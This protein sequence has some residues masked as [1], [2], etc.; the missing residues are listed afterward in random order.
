MNTA[1]GLTF[2]GTFAIAGLATSI[3][4]GL[5]PVYQLLL[6]LMLLD[7]VTGLLAAGAAK[8]LSSDVSFR[9]MFKKGIIILLVVAAHM[10]G[11]Q[12]GVPAGVGV[13]GFYCAHELLSIIENAGRAGVPVP[14]ILKQMV[15]KL[16]TTK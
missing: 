7:V 15:E 16:S 1:I 9:G 12:I 2:R 13:A 10:G 8:K 14:D 11:K 6:A 5:S 4:I 3:W